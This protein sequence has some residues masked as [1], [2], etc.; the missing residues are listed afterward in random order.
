MVH[1]NLAGRV[2]SLDY[3]I[4]DRLLD[5]LTMSLPKITT[6]RIPSSAGR[7]TLRAPYII[8][9]YGFQ[10]KNR[11]CNVLLWY[12]TGR[13]LSDDPH[14]FQETMYRLYGIKLDTSQAELMLHIE[15]NV[16]EL[17]RG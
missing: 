17:R 16:E 5:L 1:I 2:D 12:D 14:Q 6:S 10:V 9:R 13:L 7:W 8:Q 15:A 3:A 4:C 11:D